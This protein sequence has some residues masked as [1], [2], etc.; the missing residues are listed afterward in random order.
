MVPTDIST[1]GSQEKSERAAEVIFAAG[2]TYNFFHI[3]VDEG[4]GIVKSVEKSISELKF[5]SST[6]SSLPIPD[7]V[8]ITHSHDDQIRELTYC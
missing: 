1:I 7:A 8:L 2:K 3:L 4:Q 5:S 6:L